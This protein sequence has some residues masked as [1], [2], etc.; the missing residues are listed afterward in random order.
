MRL[1]PGADAGGISMTRNGQVTSRNPTAP[2]VTK[3]DQLQ[4]E[5]REGPCVSAMDDPAADG[6][7]LADDL[8]GPD[9]DRWPRLGQAEGILIERYGVD[10]EAFQMLVRSS[11]DTN[12][13]LV[14]VAR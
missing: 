9:G 1:V 13:K 6:V 2:G 5:L 3:L 8:A 12:L 4:S 14:E 7:V 11:Q 10:D